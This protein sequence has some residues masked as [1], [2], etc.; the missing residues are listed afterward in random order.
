MACRL[1]LLCLI[2]VSAPAGAQPLIDVRK[3]LAFGVE[4]VESVAARAYA[5]RLQQLADKG[6]L[7]RDAVLLGRLQVI[8]ERLRTAAE[9]EL[10]ESDAI[11]WQLHTCRRCHENAA[12]MA[13][14][15][16]LFGEEF[17]TGL[18][19]TDAELAYLVA[20]E[21]VHVLAEHTREYATTARFF[22]A[23]GLH[24][25]YW[26]IQREL[27]ES[28]VVNLRMSHEYERQELDADYY[29]FI[30]GA[31]AGFNPEAMLSL[32]RKLGVDEPSMLS[33]HP[34]ERRRMQQARTML[35][36]A[37]RIYERG[38]TQRD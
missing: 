31:R 24:R 16:L 28:I 7:D 3:D 9:Y 13:G 21:M 34:G 29:G 36:S 30:L 35:E 5:R 2:L 12:A 8:L 25:E 18:E 6:L 33:R 26:D 20:H 4:A 32:L 14:G 11:R 19:L 27:D 38:N 15:R 37:R 23:N 10:P 17:I 1:L 22:V